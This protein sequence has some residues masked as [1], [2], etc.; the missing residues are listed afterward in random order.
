[1]IPDAVHLMKC[2]QLGRVQVSV[3]TGLRRRPRFLR[4]F[5]VDA[6]TPDAGRLILRPNGWGASG[7]EN[8]FSIEEIDAV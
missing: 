4:L 7:L 1:M 5:R 6:N 3:P 2:S 8:A